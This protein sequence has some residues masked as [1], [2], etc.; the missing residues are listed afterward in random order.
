[1]PSPAFYQQIG[2]NIQETKFPQAI[3][4]DIEQSQNSEKLT[5]L[6]AIRMSDVHAK[7]IAWLWE[8]L[9]ALQTF[10]L[11]EREEGIGKTFLVCALAC[12]VG[13]GKGL[14]F[15]SEGK[16]I[17]PSNVLLISAEDSLS[18][19]LK[20]RLEA[21]NAPC[22]KII[23]IDEPFTFDEKGLLQLSAVLAEYNPRLV[24]ID[25]LFSYTGRINLDRDNDIRSI[26]DKLKRLAEKHNCCI[27]GTRHIGKSKGLGDARNAGLNGVAWRASARSALLIGKHLENKK[28]HYAKPKTILPPSSRN[29]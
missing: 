7:P 28:K 13:R 5:F 27:I 3:I 22:D 19:V 16:H 18:Y 1:M 6:K 20:P 14:P 21:M 24:V 23:A 9:L 15:V 11:L 4:G 17:E 10:N 29:Q 12:A 2:H 25:P 8:P 26:T